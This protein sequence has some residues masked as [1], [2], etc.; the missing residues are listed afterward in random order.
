MIKTVLLKGLLPLAILF[1]AVSYMGYLNKTRPQ[2]PQTAPPERVDLV[3]VTPAR[4]VGEH[5]TVHA[6]GRVVASR[7]TMLSPEVTGRVVEVNPKLV[8]GGLLAAGEVAFRLDAEDYQ[9]AVRQLAAQVT[10]ARVELQQE[11]GRRAVAEQEWKLLSEDVATTDEGTALALRRP[12]LALAK[13]NLAAAQSALAQARL[14]EDK[15][16]ITVPF[17]ATVKM[18]TVEEGLLAGPQAQL[19][20]LVGTDTFWIDAA[21]PID[22]LSWIDIPGINGFAGEH[23]ATVKI[24]QRLGD[25][26]EIT[27]AGRILR[28]DNRLDQLG[29]QA[30]VLIE[31]QDPLLVAAD[32]EP[33]MPLL[34]NA[35][36]Q[37]EIEGHPVPGAVEVPRVALRDGGTVWVMNGE[38]RLDVRDVDIVWRDEDAVLVRRGVTVGDH[39]ITSRL[40]T[41]VPGMKVRVATE[42]ARATPAPAP[43]VEGAAVPGEGAEGDR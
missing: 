4:E 12:Q 16:V 6:V 36:V 10:R 29:V 30:R 27:R 28:L 11:A 19:V 20:A 31:V 32:A 15:T 42:T 1:G 25:G 40:P 5:V 23:G 26:H 21:V 8:V 18:E 37:L 2:A 38:E 43:L 3:E 9:L 35:F 33:G 41:P 22:K 39:I 14:R 34:L 17:N 24:T 7:E 13:A